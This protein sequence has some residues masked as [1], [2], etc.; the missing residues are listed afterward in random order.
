MG[1][2]L[3]SYAYQD[4]RRILG[5]LRTGVRLADAPWPGWVEAYGK[6]FA[7]SAA[8]L[9]ESS[10]PDR[11][12]RIRHFVPRPGT[13]AATAVQDTTVRLEIRGARVGLQAVPPFA[14][15]RSSRYTGYAPT[16][17]AIALVIAT[18][19]PWRRRA[20][21]LLWAALLA[22]GFSALMLAIWIHEWFY[23]QECIWLASFSEGYAWRGRI[24]GS[25][26]GITAWPGPY[27]IAPV[28]IWI[29][30]SFRATDLDSILEK[31]RTS[32]GVPSPLPPV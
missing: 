3:D 1:A 20:W 18:P 11:S 30:A 9:F 7:S 10:N 26:V 16:A 4:D 28:L 25:L 8:L 27:Y 29:L 17:L 23:G 22:S 19:I 15:A 2:W 21:A 31:T 13:S 12:I 32:A 14:T 24:V 5:P 6:V